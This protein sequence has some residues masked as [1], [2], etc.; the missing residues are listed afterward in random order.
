[1]AVLLYGLLGGLIGL[2]TAEWMQVRA[3]R[4]RFNSVAVAAIAAMLS[5]RLPALLEAPDA[6]RVLA[7]GLVAALCTLALNL[8]RR[9]VR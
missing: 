4:A 8:L 5:S 7:A 3:H 1:M 2:A 9:E 6:G